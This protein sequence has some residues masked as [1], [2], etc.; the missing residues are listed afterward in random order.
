MNDFFGD[1]LIWFFFIR[2]RCWWNIDQSNVS[3]S[4]YGVFDRGSGCL[5]SRIFHKS[6]RSC[7]NSDAAT[8]RVTGSRTTC[9]ILQVK[10]DCLVFANHC[11][12][13]PI[14]ISTQLLNYNTK[15]AVLK[16]IWNTIDKKRCYS[17]NDF[18]L[19]LW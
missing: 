3:W 1:N 13:S 19:C 2:E 5:W 18:Y 7:Q 15:N 8:R 14:S 12:G 4:T 9:H 6:T 11:F 10:F 16:R 17:Q